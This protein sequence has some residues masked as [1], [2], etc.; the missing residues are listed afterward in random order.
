MCVCQSSHKVLTSGIHG[1]VDVKRS[2]TRRANS[3]CVG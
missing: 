2:V 1:E 3:M